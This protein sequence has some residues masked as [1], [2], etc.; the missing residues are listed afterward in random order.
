[1]QQQHTRTCHQSAND[2]QLRV[3]TRNFHTFARVSINS[4]I[5]IMYSPFWRRL[6]FQNVFCGLR[7]GLSSLNPHQRGQYMTGI[8]EF[9]LTP[10]ML[11]ILFL[12]SHF[13]FLFILCG[14]LSWLSVSVLLH[15]KYTLSYRIVSYRIVTN[16]FTSCCLPAPSMKK[17]M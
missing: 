5:P 11:I 10:I 17:L 4:V 9:M 16:K 3:C 2:R 6:G 7:K 14:R 1:M 15:V 12:V 8:T 13:N